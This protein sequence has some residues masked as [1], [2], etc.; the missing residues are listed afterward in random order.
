[1]MKSRGECDGN[2]EEAAAAAEDE[3]DEAC[4]ESYLKMCKNLGKIYGWS[5][6]YFYF[7]MYSSKMFVDYKRIITLWS[8]K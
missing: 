6:N 1:M 8:S 2:E 7:V 5:L 4:D 3:E